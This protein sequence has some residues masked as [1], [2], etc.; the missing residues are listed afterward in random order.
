MHAGD[1]KHVKFKQKIPV[2]IAYFTA[3]VDE[4]AA[5]ISSPTF[6]GTTNRLQNCRIAGLQKGRPG[7]SKSS[8]S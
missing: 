4:K 3:W 7:S 1:E 6:T 5:S 8:L 2:H